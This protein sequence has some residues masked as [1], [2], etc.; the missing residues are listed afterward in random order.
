MNVNAVRQ[1]QGAF[2]EVSLNEKQA[3]E[4]AARIAGE[5]MNLERARRR[6][7]EQ[8]EQIAPFVTAQQD[9]QTHLQRARHDYRAV[10]LCCHLLDVGVTAGRGMI[11]APGVEI[12]T[13]RCPVDA[14]VDVLRTVYREEAL[15]VFASLGAPAGGPTER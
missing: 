9:V 2:A 5:L 15:K 13:I 4:A 7:V 11:A 8:L 14:A 10:Q 12:Q 3:N 1:L 6:I